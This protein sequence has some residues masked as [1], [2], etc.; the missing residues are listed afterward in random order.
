MTTYLSKRYKRIT[1]IINIE[2]RITATVNVP[3]MLFMHSKTK[4]SQVTAITAVTARAMT[5]AV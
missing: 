4:P 5:A 1:T 2:S 3:N